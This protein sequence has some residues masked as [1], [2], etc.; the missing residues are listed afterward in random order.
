[1]LLR[2]MSEIVRGWVC[3]PH[4]GGVQAPIPFPDV[5]LAAQAG[6]PG[7]CRRLWETYAP[8]VAR[9]ARAR[10]SREPEDLTSEVFLTMFRT[11]PRFEGGE[12]A[13]K[14]FL[15]TVAHR[16]LVDELRAR[17]RCPQAT[18]WEDETDPRRAPS[19]EDGAL[20]SLGS[21][22]ARQ[23]LDALAPDQR[24]VL[25]LRIF[26]DLTIEQI[27][28]TLGKQ[29]GAV[30]ALQRRGMTAL[31]KNFACGHTPAGLTADGSQ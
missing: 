23:M 24:D 30:K 12:A 21:G 17:S 27:A 2:E 29:P 31:R 22:Q 1:M 19:A 26:G 18:T 3:G 15:F 16:R 20:S 11:L 10:G 14:G 13:F 7:A 4:T 9:Y 28:E 8:A 5:L 25:V 6:D